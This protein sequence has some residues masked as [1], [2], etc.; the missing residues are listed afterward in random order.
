MAWGG[1][2]KVA[3]LSPGVRSSKKLAL[4]LAVGH[5]PYKEKKR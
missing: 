3:S 2:K 5:S 1:V 4:F